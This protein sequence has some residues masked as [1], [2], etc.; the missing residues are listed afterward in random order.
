MSLS[1]DNAVVHYLGIEGPAVNTDLDRIS[2]GDLVCQ[3]QAGTRCLH[4]LLYVTL[5]RTGTVGRVI[6]RIRDEAFG[7]ICEVDRD[8]AFCQS[9]VEVLDDQVDDSDG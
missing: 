2:F 3:D 9:S 6:S 4:I 8:P 7:L 1:L 5:E